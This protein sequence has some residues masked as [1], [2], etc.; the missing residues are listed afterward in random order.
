VRASSAKQKPGNRILVNF[1]KVLIV[2]VLTLPWVAAGLTA[3]ALYNTTAQSNQ[4]I[5]EQQ[6]R[7]ELMATERE[8]MLE[9]LS[10]TGQE[11]D[12][13][14][15]AKE[16]LQQEIYELERNPSAT[17]TRSTGIMGAAG[18]EE[19]ISPSNEQLEELARQVIMG[20]WGNGRI[21]VD[22]LENAG[23]NFRTIQQRVNEIIWEN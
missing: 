14:R 5:R 9:D 19:K 10:S 11:L 7:I 2:S 21:R 22:G 16:L 13:L 6:D 12:A 18:A 15:Q 20:N 3:L 17:A 8:D 4:E 23:Y 1:F